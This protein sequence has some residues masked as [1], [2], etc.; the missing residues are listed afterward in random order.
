MNVFFVVPTLVAGVLITACSS[1]GGSGEYC[2]RVTDKAVGYG[3]IEIRN[4]LGT[5]VSAF[6]PEFPFEALVRPDK[7]EIYGV[8]SG[9]RSLE[10]TQCNFQSDNVCVTFG[11]AVNIAVGVE[12]DATEVVQISDLF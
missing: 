10:L 4:D 8:P 2:E 12:P 5:G 3:D 7:C 6:F 1:G 11:A 9:N